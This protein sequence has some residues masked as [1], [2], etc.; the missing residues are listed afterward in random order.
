MANDRTP[1]APLN[2][3]EALAGPFQCIHIDLYRPL[4]LLGS[5]KYV[6]VMTDVFTKWVEVEAIPDK[7]A[8]TVA[9]KVFC[10]WI[11]RF[12]SMHKLVSDSGG[13]SPTRSY[14]SC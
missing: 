14:A 12:G 8:P 7:S 2:P 3:W 13:N 4:T 9:E 6:A 10:S 11:C 1:R 5:K